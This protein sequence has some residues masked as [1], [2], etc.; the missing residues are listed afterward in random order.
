[1]STTPR[2]ATDPS[3]SVLAAVPRGSSVRA[4]F[5]HLFR[6]NT[7]LFVANMVTA[8]A[9]YLY[10]V[11]MSHLLGQANYGTVA[12]LVSL[13]YIVLIPTAVTLVVCTRA[14]AALFA[15]D[16]AGHLR[17]LWTV[18]TLW[19]L[20][21][22]VIATAVFSLGLSGMVA[23]FLQISLHGNGS[24]VAVLGLLFVVGFVSPLNQGILQGMQRF[25]WVAT[26]TAGG[27]LLRIALAAIF[28][29]IGWGVTGAILGLVL[30]SLFPYLLTMLPVRAALRQAPR[31]ATALRPWLRYSTTVTI[32]MI[33][34]TLLYNVDTILAKHFLPPIEA[35]NYAALANAGKIVYFVSGSVATVMFAKV[36]AAHVRGEQHGHLLAFSLGA[37]LAL[38]LAVLAVF[39][40]FP[41][42]VLAHLFGPAYVVV[43][44]DL[45]WYAL[46]MLL[47]SLAG[48]LMQYFLS[49]DNRP[50]LWIVVACCLGQTSALWVWHANV[51]EMV[52]VMLVTMAVLLAL[53]GGLYVARGT[54]QAAPAL[55]ESPAP[56]L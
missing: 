25:G 13:T 11:V 7:L 40:A 9:S 19:L 4:S 42:F 36:A 47:F 14:A 17:E 24:A 5:G 6:L 32:A 15:R 41:G 49:V 20:V 16:E 39:V 45:P 31:Q 29:L 12:A 27:A 28:V 23:R 8:V 44:G 51:T 48:V 3:D 1:M 50:F 46:A 10:H 43:R 30:S 54:R 26:I 35:G 2:L 33:G 38:S 55:A 22:G 34:T 52:W 37:V 53:L 21:L 56:V 18:L